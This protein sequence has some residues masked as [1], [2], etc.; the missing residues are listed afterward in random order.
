MFQ[1]GGEVVIRLL[2]H[3][4]QTTIDPLIRAMVRPG[5]QVYT[6]E[7]DIYARLR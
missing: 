4:Q 7:Y 3:V 2:E 6:D 1:R 5:T